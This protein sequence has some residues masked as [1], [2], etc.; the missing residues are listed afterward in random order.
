MIQWRPYVKDRIKLS[1]G[2]CEFTTE[3]TRR[4]KSKET[5]FEAKGRKK[6]GATSKDELLKKVVI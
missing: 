6:N 3:K 5:E 4:S 1:F 2:R